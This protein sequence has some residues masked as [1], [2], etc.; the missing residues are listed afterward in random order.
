MNRVYDLLGKIDDP[1]L[2][3]ELES[4]IGERVNE[5]EEEAIRQ[6]GIIIMAAIRGDL[7]AWP[8]CPP[9]WSNRPEGS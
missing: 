9:R 5:A 2:F 4:A 8:G 7:V 1:G 6:Q 3:G